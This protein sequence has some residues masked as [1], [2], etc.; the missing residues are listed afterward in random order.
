[1]QA[2]LAMEQRNWNVTVY[3]KYH[4]LF[5]TNRLCLRLIFD[6]VEKNHA[7]GPSKKSA[8]FLSTNFFFLC[9]KT[10]ASRMLR[11]NG[12]HCT[13]KLHE[14]IKSNSSWSHAIKN[15]KSNAVQSIDF[16]D[17]H[18]PT[19]CW[20]KQISS[21]RNSVFFLHSPLW[22]FTLHSAG[23]HADFDL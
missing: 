10:Y 1:M 2:K 7:E 19:G 22:T 9:P 18:Q 12:V 11:S 4:I 13:A 17:D 6:C 5:V 8:T 3:E 20:H 15:S 14:A 23:C 21:P 16:V